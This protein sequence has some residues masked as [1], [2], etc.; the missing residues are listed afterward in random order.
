MKRTTASLLASGALLFATVS[1]I[2]PMTQISAQAE[3]VIGSRRAVVV[4]VEG[5]RNDRGT[6]VGALYDRAS[7]WLREENALEDC[8][9]PIHDG[10]ARCVFGPPPDT[11]V[12]FAA[13]HDEDDDGELD[14]DLLGIPQEG[15]AF[16]NDVREPFGPP[17]FEA[18]SFTPSAT[19]P[20]VVHAR[21]GL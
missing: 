15:Y 4:V 19:A 16:S 6:L 2:L 20:R 12:A 9:A 1:P 11:R 3:P 17:S 7:T 13:L 18:A 14:R 8:H 5:L 10:Y 21:Y